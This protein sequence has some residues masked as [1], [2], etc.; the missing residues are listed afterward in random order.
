MMRDPLGSVVQ[1]INGA[2]TPG[3]SQRFAPYGTP[4]LPTSGNGQGGTDLRM[5]WVGS[6]GY[7]RTS[8]V[9]SERYV[10]ARHY[11]STSGR[12]TTRDRWWPRRPSFGM[13]NGRVLAA[14]DPTGLT[15]R[16]SDDLATSLGTKNPSPCASM[17]ASLSSG[18]IVDCMGKL[19]Y[20]NMGPFVDFMLSL[21]KGQAAAS[22]KATDIC[23]LGPNDVPPGLIRSAKCGCEKW[24]AK[25]IQVFDRQSQI[26]DAAWPQPP[27]PTKNSSNVCHRILNPYEQTCN[28]ALDQYFTKLSP[29]GC[30]CRVVVCQ[31][32]ARGSD[33][34]ACALLAHEMVH[35]AGVGGSPLHDWT[36]KDR[37]NGS[38]A[39]LDGDAINAFS[40][41]T[42]CSMGG[43]RCRECPGPHD[44][45]YIDTRTGLITPR[46]SVFNRGCPS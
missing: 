31:Y 27:D 39:Q 44:P 2:D 1:T 43:Q 15:I 18:R 6:W 11:S 22:N 34:D 13:V 23:V 40:C 41:C 16:V 21:L 7:R 38:N 20:P 29:G 25:A 12:W 42:C 46:F 8:M 35:C 3:L 17:F 33:A 4:T 30:G 26:P 32:N 36:Q 37:I 9:N 28:E 5:G 19:G 10:R 24:G 14:I 45:N